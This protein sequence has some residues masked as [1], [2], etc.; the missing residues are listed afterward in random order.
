MKELL[1]EIERVLETAS[2]K[3]GEATGIPEEIRPRFFTGE[4]GDWIFAAIE[5]TNHGRV[6]YDGT[7]TNMKKGLVVRLTPDLAE[8][9][10][11]LAA[12]QVSS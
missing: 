6:G 11:K 9:A 7:T 2:W 4:A 1:E 3:L 8:K 10:V 12:A 5:F